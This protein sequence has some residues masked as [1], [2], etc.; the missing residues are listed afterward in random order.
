MRQ[1][2]LVWRLFGNHCACGCLA[3]APKPEDLKKGGVK[4]RDTDLRPVPKGKTKRR[5]RVEQR[6]NERA[7]HMQ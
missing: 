7:K 4:T 1:P 6:E 2:T 5:L 3:P